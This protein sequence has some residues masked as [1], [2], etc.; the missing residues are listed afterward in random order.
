M[1]AKKK[2]A[3]LAPR[4]KVFKFGIQVPRTIKEAYEL[5]A[6]NGNTTYWQDAI[7]LEMDALENFDAFEFHP[8]GYNPGSD[9]Q[10][11]RLRMIFDVKADTLR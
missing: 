3:G 4:G 10:S 9:Y 7:K 8:K 5:D 1:I 6:A 2:K 11:T